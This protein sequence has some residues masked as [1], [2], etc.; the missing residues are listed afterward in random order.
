MTVFDLKRLA[1][2]AATTTPDDLP[3]EH[4]RNLAHSV[5]WFHYFP[6]YD[7]LMKLAA[8]IQP[9]LIVE[10]GV[11]FGRG[12]AFM[13]EGAPSATVWGVDVCPS[14][15]TQREVLWPYSD[16]VRV[17]H[18]DSVR[19]FLEHPELNVD[20]LFI[21][22]S[23]LLGQTKMEWRVWRPQMV[24]GGIVCFD[25]LN[26]PG[27]RPVWDAEIVDQKVELPELRPDGGGFGAVIC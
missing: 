9:K 19:F 5:L 26:N 21:D 1:E 3:S 16:R 24:L 6:Y 2:Q 10:L 11:S 12:M 25:D 18:E 17:F 22:S 20:L 8:A 14:T 23:H 27:V 13:A 15:P 4:L 7:F